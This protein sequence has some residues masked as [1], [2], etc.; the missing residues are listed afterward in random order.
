MDSCLGLKQSSFLNCLVPCSVPPQFC[1][2]LVLAYILASASIYSFVPSAGSL[3][4]VSLNYRLGSTF[5][6]FSLL[7]LG[8][9]IEQEH[10]SSMVL[11]LS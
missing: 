9:A 3:E 4:T 8:P 6:I 1:V 10:E 7:F 5:L 11:E 2:D